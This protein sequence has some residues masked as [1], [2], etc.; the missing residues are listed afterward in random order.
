MNRWPRK[1]GSHHVAFIPKTLMF[2]K[3]VMRLKAQ[4]PPGPFRPPA[5][6]IGSF[7]VIAENRFHPV[8]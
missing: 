8:W 3:V 1:A 6:L 4:Q 7:K 2:L 5:G